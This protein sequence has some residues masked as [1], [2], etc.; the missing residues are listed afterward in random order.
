MSTAHPDPSTTHAALAAA[1]QDLLRGQPQAMTPAQARLLNLAAWG[2]FTAP[3]GSAH[4][5]E[6]AADFAA[7]WQRQRE[8]A[9]VLAPL[10][11]AWRALGVQAVAFKGLALAWAAYPHPALR[12]AGD[13]DVLID[14]AQAASARQVAVPGWRVVQA[15]EPKADLACIL[16]HE[17]S[18]L[19]VEVHTCIVPAHCSGRRHGDRVTR[20]MLDAAV[21][22]PPVPPG[23]EAPPAAWHMLAP[24][25]L[26]LALA[27]NR[28]WSTDAWR[29]KPHDYLD[30][31]HL[32][33]RHGATEAAVAARARELGLGRTWTLFTE[34]CSPQARRFD[35]VATRRTRWQRW[36]KD[37]STWHGGL[38]PRLRGQLQL[39]LHRLPA[40]GRTLRAMPVLAG[41]LAALRAHPTPAD[42]ASRPV[43]ARPAGQAWPVWK[44][45]Q[46]ARRAHDILGPLCR[47][48]SDAGPCVVESLTLHRLLQHHGHDARWCLG[49][50]QADGHGS[51]IAH[52]W[53]E[54]PDP[55]ALG[56]EYT[57]RSAQYRPAYR[58]PA[59]APGAA[60]AP[61][62]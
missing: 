17:R 48:L 40:L 13:V 11:D 51:P 38:P 30:L 20:A 37:W 23:H 47:K 15:G 57:L 9:S 46:A 4:R 22:P 60:L 6:L 21:P 59:P 12:F 50:R 26:A 44:V 45:E 18:R 14:P 53:V 41:V 2:Y 1:A 34:H 55:Y 25:D 32:A 58:S 35:P 36:R 27:L 49:Y 29:H 7:Q 24:V 10:F 56:I 16:F 39:T 62:P 19:M 5:A 8:R 3:P 31:Q 33:D 54:L 52:A 61:H 28:A 43:R 42:V